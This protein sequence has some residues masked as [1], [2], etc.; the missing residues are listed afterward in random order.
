MKNVKEIDVQLKAKGKYAIIVARFNEFIT[1]EMKNGA[2]KSLI[3]QGVKEENITVWHVPG[4]FEI[5]VL[6]SKI[7]KSGKYD[8]IITLGA[9]IKGSTAHFDFVSGAVTNAVNSVA[10]ETGVPTIFGVITVDTIEQAIER[11]GSKA[12]NKGS[13]AALTALEM[14]NILETV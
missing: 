2:L 14:V 10:L 8:A 5:G 6:A 12:G 3:K 4:A 7:A 13:E 9:V 1:L 11:A